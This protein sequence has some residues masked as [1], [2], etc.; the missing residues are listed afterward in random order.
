MTTFPKK[1][2]P[3]AP[4]AV[5]AFASIGSCTG[6][7]GPANALTL[8][9]QPMIQLDCEI[10]GYRRQQACRPH[11][12]TVPSRSRRTLKLPGSAAMP[13]MNKTA[14]PAHLD[15]FLQAPRIPHGGSRERVTG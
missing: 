6:A 14:R 4:W 3:A 5:G 11:Q 7:R 15:V 10:D 9:R 12:L 13:L 2:T 1:L 8:P